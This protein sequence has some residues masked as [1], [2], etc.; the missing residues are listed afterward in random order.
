[1]HANE[2]TLLLCTARFLNLVLYCMKIFTF[3]GG[4]SGHWTVPSYRSSHEHSPLVVSG[5]FEVWGHLKLFWGHSFSM[6]LSIHYEWTNTSLKSSHVLLRCSVLSVYCLPLFDGSGVPEC[7][8]RT[9]S[10]IQLTCIMTRF[11]WSQLW[12]S[13]VTNKVI[14]Y[15]LYI[16]FDQFGH[17]Y[18]T[19][20]LLVYFEIVHFVAW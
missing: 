6:R 19:S 18:F 3:L 5:A 15:S 17:F 9:T 2:Q 14:V 16:G 12:I 7:V 13:Q 1:M 8:L 11:H 10:L 20:L 4:G